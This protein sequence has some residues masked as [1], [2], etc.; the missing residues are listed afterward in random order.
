MYFVSRWTGEGLL[1]C[2]TLAELPILAEERMIDADVSG[3]IRSRG[4]AAAK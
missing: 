3:Y 2:G 4:L 1:V